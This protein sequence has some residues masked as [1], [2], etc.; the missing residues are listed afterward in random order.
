MSQ[1]DYSALSKREKRQLEDP[2][3]Q[4]KYINVE[5]LPILYLG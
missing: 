2:L 4:D 3:G 5:G 1:E